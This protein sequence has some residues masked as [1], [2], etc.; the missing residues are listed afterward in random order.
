MTA[1]EHGDTASR[2]RY[3]DARAQ[4]VGADADGLVGVVGLLTQLCRSLTAKIAVM[5]AAV[6]LMSAGGSEGVAAASDERSRDVGELQFAMGEGPCHEAFAARRP[7]LTPDL[8][9][10]PDGRWPGY[11]PAALASGVGAVFA[12]PLHVGAVTFGVLD[13]YADRPG[14]LSV[15][16]EVWA[17]TFA[18][19]AT[20]ILLDGDLTTANGELDPGLSTALDSRAEIHQAQGMVVVDLGIDPAMA[21]ARMRAHAFAHNRPLIDLAREIIDGLRLEEGDARP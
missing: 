17:L 5:G 6:N 19:I 16:Q 8:R 20:E 15:E 2:Q 10:I 7:V 1:T 4:I 13:V 12:F 21:L 3:D 14:S 11:A 9:A 18:Q